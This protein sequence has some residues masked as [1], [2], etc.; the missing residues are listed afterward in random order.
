MK[1]C[2][3]SND[4]AA[5]QQKYLNV[6]LAHELWKDIKFEFLQ[7]SYDNP[8][9]VRYLFRLLWRW[10]LFIFFVFVVLLYPL[11]HAWFGDAPPQVS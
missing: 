2:H 1:D 5:T 7:I 11:S 4:I 8:S 9:T 3:E 10:Q 6:N